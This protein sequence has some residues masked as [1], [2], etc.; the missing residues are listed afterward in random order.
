MSTD[1]KPSELAA[2]PAKT[3]CSS[4]PFEVGEMLIV[5]YCEQPCAKLIAVV[6][7][8]SES[9]DM[10][11]WKYLNA[12]PMLDYCNNQNGFFRMEKATRVE[13]FGVKV[14]AHDGFYWCEKNGDSV[15]TYEDGKPRRWQ[16]RTS[17]AVDEADHSPTPP[18]HAPA[19]QYRSESRNDDRRLRARE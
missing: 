10:C 7:D 13:D 3:V 17:L 12:D 6:V 18:S 19:L 11:N 14:M 5:S 16:G 4:R 9:G 1:A 15:A 2:N 8:A